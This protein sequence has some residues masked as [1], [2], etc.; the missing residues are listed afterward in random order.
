MATFSRIGEKKGLSIRQ[1][2]W[3]ERRRSPRDVRRDMKSPP[4][5][6]RLLHL[7]RGNIFLAIGLERSQE[8]AAYW[9][10]LVGRKAKL[11]VNWILR[12]IIDC[13]WH[14]FFFFSF[15]VVLDLFVFF[16]WRG[17]TLRIY[18]KVFVK[19]GRLFKAN[20]RFP[21]ANIQ[22]FILLVLYVG[23]AFSFCSRSM[24]NTICVYKATS[25]NNRKN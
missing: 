24:E 17:K 14:N 12:I 8:G 19:R 18:S 5:S 20:L 4:L 1:L 13:I 6:V 25:R 3:A 22:Y 15:L 21:N 9:R 7:E 23:Y 10:T 11:A 16:T 2:T